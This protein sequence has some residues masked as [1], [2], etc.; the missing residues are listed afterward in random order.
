M[1]GPPEVGPS[2][3]ASDP[4][5]GVEMERFTEKR[6]GRLRKYVRKV[7]RMFK[8]EDRSGPSPDSISTPA[9]STGPLS[10]PAILP[11]IET[12][13]SS[14]P[15]Q[16]DSPVVEVTDSPTP[17]VDANNKADTSIQA[18]LEPAEE[19]PEQVPEQ[20]ATAS[21]VETSDPSP[22]VPTIE[23]P[24]GPPPLPSIESSDRIS[25]EPVDTSDRPVLERPRKFSEEP[26]WE[27]EVNN[28]TSVARIR[29]L[30]EPWNLSIEPHEWSYSKRPANV[31]RVE[32][33]IRARIHRMCHR[34]STGF[35]ATKI[36]T[37]CG[38]SRCKLCPRLPS[39]TTE[40]TP[41][42]EQPR[43][44]T[45]PED[46]PT[47]PEIA[48]PS[49]SEEQ[50]PAD[51]NAGVEDTSVQPKI[52]HATS[53]AVPTQAAVG[54]ASS[55]TA[56]GGMVGGVDLDLDDFES[57]RKKYIM[58]RPIRTGGQPLVKKKPMQRVRRTC[59]E[60]Q[61]LFQPN[62]RSC[63][64]CGHHRCDDCPRDPPK[65]DKYPNGYPGDIP[66]TTPRLITR[67]CHYCSHLFPPIPRFPGSAD[68]FSN[69][70]PD[71][72]PI[73]CTNCG[74]IQCH[75][76]L[77]ESPKIIPS[78]V[79]AVPTGSRSRVAQLGPTVGGGMSTT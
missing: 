46:V 7:K 19:K 28:L 31:S 12:V 52:S 14:A 59:H 65:R 51:E 79:S 34:C 67:S 32:R 6:R 45:P 70:G 68:R 62:S 54:Q 23:T 64:K 11:S 17:V 40:E 66:T 77:I 35:G 41:Q 43:A 27:R 74:H 10:L 50:A 56:I 42:P 20:I 76:C 5:A 75:E 2:S 63:P 8:G 3:S 29:R 49:K 13:E 57:L 53:P 36:C 69:I 9:Q 33:P 22:S 21:V 25:P 58:S 44:A 47:Q 48:L 60:C 1:G 55:S 37:N 71:G 18:S 30:G 61:S 78:P 15:Q 72:E 38:H 73:E 26:D 24:Q 39:R 4:M 16:R